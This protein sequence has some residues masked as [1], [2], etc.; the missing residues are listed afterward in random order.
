M[1]FKVKESQIAGYFSRGYAV[2]EGVAPPSLI[3]GLRRLE[4]RCRALLT[5]DATNSRTDKLCDGDANLDVQPV[6]DLSQLPQLHERWR[7]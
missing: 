7:S 3:G 5:A 2:V 6:R 1:T 4:G